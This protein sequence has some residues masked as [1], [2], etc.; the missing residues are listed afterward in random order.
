MAGDGLAQRGKLGGG[1]LVAR[2][3]VAHLG[4]LGGG[5]HEVGVERLARRRPPPALDAG[6]QRLGLA[7]ELVEAAAV[8]AGDG[9]A[10]D[11][12]VRELLADGVGAARDLLDAL[13]SGGELGAGGLALALTVTLQALDRRGELYAG[14]LRGLLVLGAD[15]LELGGDVDAP[16]RAS[17][18]ARA[19]SKRRPDS[20]IAST[21]RASAAAT[22][23]ARRASAWARS[24]SSWSTRGGQAGR[25]R[26]RRRR[27]WPAPRG[28]RAR[29]AAATRALHVGAQRLG[30]LVAGLLARLLELRRQPAG[31]ALELVDA[32]QRAQQARD[33]RGGVVEVG[34]AA[35]DARI[36]VREPLLGLRVGGGALGLAA[37]QLGLDPRGRGQRAEDDERAGGAP[38]LPR[39]RPGS[40]AWLSARTTTGC[41][42]RMRSSI[43][44]IGS[45][46]DRSS[47]K[48]EKSKPSS[49]LTGTKTASSGKTSPSERR[50]VSWTVPGACGGSPVARNP[51]QAC[52]SGG[53]ASPISVSKK[54]WPRMSSAGWP[55]SSSAGSDHL[56][57]DPWPSVRTK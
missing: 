4:H 35:L 46:K 25:A 50:P 7:L 9:G 20:A 38:A 43:R 27:A 57:T 13:E 16:T 48:S 45:S 49:S 34:D 32:L 22:A 55:N 36:E 37:R 1:R 31:D 30:A 42:W 17:R 2:D 12:D 26:P 18:P 41:C 14:G 52:P 53:S 54:P 15:L 56:E 3:N 39:L 47:R 10:L 33:D 19:V 8:V 40:S 5:G 23:S 29:S 6:A 11:G 21:A 28:G 51:R 24:R 44:F